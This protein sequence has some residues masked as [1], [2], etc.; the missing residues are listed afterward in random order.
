[1]AY[2]LGWVL[3]WVC[4]LLIV[5]YFAWWWLQLRDASWESIVDDLSVSVVPPLVLP[6]VGLYG[7]GRAL[8]YVLSNE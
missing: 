8:R 6:A 3:Y 4:L 5:L 2:R 1:M 7:I